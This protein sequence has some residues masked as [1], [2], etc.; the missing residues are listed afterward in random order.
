MKIA[1]AFIGT[2]KYLNFLEEY[3]E[4][5]SEKFHQKDDKHFFVFTDGEIDNPPENVSLINISEDFNI[6]QS[7][8][9]P[10]NWYKLMHQSVGGLRRFSIIKMVEDKLKDFDWFVFIDADM[11][12][13]EIVEDFFDE[14]K[15]YFGVQHPTFH[16]TWSLSTGEIPHERNNKSVSYIDP[17]EYDE[18]YLQGCVWG[19][20]IPEVIGMINELD[21]NVKID[22]EKNVLARAHDESHL[23]RFRLNNKDQFH[24]LHPKFAFPGNVPAHQFSHEPVFIHCPVNKSQILNR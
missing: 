7:D 17:S 11:F 21:N 12:C 23:N 22:I 14:T 3:Y 1:I 13:V 18:V 10:S 4:T 9:D 2:G 5:F 20:R 24:V 16:H 15:P 8:Y 6:E 19:G